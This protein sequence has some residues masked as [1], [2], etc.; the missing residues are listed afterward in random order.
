MSF[1][2]M[3]RN[4]KDFTKLV[5]KLQ[6]S[7]GNA[8]SGSADERFWKPERDKAGNGY[9]VIRFLPPTEGDDDL[10]WVRVFSHSFQGPG[11][12]F[13]ENCRTTLG[14]QHNCPVCDSN[15][16]LWN[17]GLESDKNVARDRKRKLTYISNIYVVSDPAN[18]ENEG[19]VFL[20]KYGKSIFNIVNEALEPQFADEE[21]LNPFDFWEGANFKIKIRNKDGYVNYDK[22]EFDS[23]AQLDEDEVMEKIWK[24]QYKLSEFISEDQFK[25]FEDQ[26]ARLSRV[27][28]EKKVG[29]TA[30][31]AVDEFDVDE[32]VPMDLNSKFERSAKQK[33]EK[34]REEKVVEEDA[35]FDLD[36]DSDETLSYFAKLAEED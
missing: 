32:D 33:S 5:S 10:Y 28:G 7:K 11:G 23:P 25:S 3:K 21:P 24:S 18:P 13:I 9:A 14:N 26:E 34:V 22:S 36:D 20:F 35:P 19:K 12:W 6:E 31:A 15:R 29:K 17:S 16:D 1:A 30:A 4:R 27:L 8:G 2:S